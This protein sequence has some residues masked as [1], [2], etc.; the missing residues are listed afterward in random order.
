MSAQLRLANIWEPAAKSN[1]E[2]D[3]R[4]L[5]LKTKVFRQKVAAPR[6]NHEWRPT[7]SRDDLDQ[8]TRTAI[9]H[10]RSRPHETSF[11]ASGGYE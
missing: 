10:I 2:T 5:H 4:W 6:P 9:E 7:F 3:P 11:C 8:K 1:I